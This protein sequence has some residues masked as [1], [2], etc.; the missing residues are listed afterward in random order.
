MLSLFCNKTKWFSCLPLVALL[1]FLFFIVFGFLFFVFHSSQKRDPPQ[2]NRTQQKLRKKNKNAEKTDP[3][4]SVSAVAFAN[5]V[6]WLIGVGLKIHL[7][8]ENIIKIVV[9]AS[10]VKGKWPKNVKNCWVKTWSKVEWK[11]GPSMLRNIIGPSFDQ[12][13]VILVFHSLFIFW[14]SHSP[15]R[16]KKI[17]AK[18][19]GK[20]RKFGPSFDPKKGYSWTKFW[21]YS[22]YI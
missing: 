16:Q 1:P 9:S 18:L 22:I 11:L 4:K 6:P 2:K 5:S 19:K 15:C 12:K 20:R 21:L 7:F 17:F 8:A 10:F 3:K 14:K 13:W